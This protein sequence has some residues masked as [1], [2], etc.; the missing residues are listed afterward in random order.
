[1]KETEMSKEKQIEEMKREINIALARDCSKARCLTCEFINEEN[2]E[3]AIIAEWLYT[4]GYRKQ[5]EVEALENE[6]ERLER[7]LNSYALQYGTVVDQQ[8]VI[9]K[10][11]TEVVMEIDLYCIEVSGEFN[12]YRFNELKKKYAPKECPTCKHFVGCECFDGKICEEYEGV[13][14]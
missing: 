5:S 3:P 8:K 1:M 14:E 9:D 11:K 7:I 13:D 6:I 12:F 4:A 10:A 2:C